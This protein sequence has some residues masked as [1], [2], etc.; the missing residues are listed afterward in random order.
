MMDICISDV[1]QAIE[2]PKKDKP[3][4]TTLFKKTSK[5]SRIAKMTTRENNRT[6]EGRRQLNCTLELEIVEYSNQTK[7]K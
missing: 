1:S 7:V 2:I 5:T 6:S 3:L 4:K